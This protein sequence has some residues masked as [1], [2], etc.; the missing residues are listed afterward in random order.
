MPV[1]TS[2]EKLVVVTHVHQIPQRG[3]H[4]LPLGTSK[5]GLGQPLVLGS[6]QIMIGLFQL[7][8]GITMTIDA[9]SLGVFSGIFVWGSL[10]YIIAGSLTVS[11]GKSFNRCLV[12]GALGVS[13]VAAIVSTCAIILY[14][15]DAAF[16]MFG[17]CPDAYD[18]HLYITRMKGFSIMMTV[19]HFLM[20]GVSIAI[21]GYACNATCRCNTETVTYVKELEEQPQ[22]L[23]GLPGYESVIADHPVLTP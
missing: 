23:T 9:D 22:H 18:C 19:L 12:N 2:T 1:T 3:E 17:Y 4:Q 15:M 5:F 14:I 20:L 16:Q 13:V 8:F 7:L 10:I 11:A 6:I 21:A